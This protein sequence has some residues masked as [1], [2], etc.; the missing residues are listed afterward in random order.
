LGIKKRVIFILSFIIPFC[1]L[2]FSLGWFFNPY[3]STI[4]KQNLFLQKDNHVVRIDNNKSLKSLAIEPHSI[5]IQHPYR[6][7]LIKGVKLIG[8]QNAD[9]E[10]HF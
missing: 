2:F 5:P 3:G 7:G 8:N 4:I 1:L 6:C 10:E 9:A